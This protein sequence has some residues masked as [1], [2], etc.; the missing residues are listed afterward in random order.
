MQEVIKVDLISRNIET[1]LVSK[2]KIILNTKFL[3]SRLCDLFGINYLTLI[4]KSR[5]RE[6]VQARQIIASFCYAMAK[7]SLITISRHLDQDHATVLHSKKTVINL[8]DTCN[9][10]KEYIKYLCYNLYID[11]DLFYKKLNT[12]KEYINQYYY[13]Y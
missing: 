12:S 1:V 9:S 3:S 4:K 7:E 5:K 8:I 6:L 11:Y 13:K 10:F 2:I